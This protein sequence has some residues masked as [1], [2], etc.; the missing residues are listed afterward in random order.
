VSLVR[1]FARA[2]LAGQVIRRLRRAGVAEARYDAAT[3][4]VRFRPVGHDGAAIMSLEILLGELTGSRRERRARVDAFVDGFIRVPDMPGT[5]EQ[6]CPRLR[7]VLRGA[8]PMAGEKLPAPLRRPALP[9]LSELV[10]VDQPDT[11]TFVAP[12]LLDGWGVSEDE[13][14]AAART[15]LSQVVHRRAAPAPVVLRFVDDGDAYWTSHLLI[16]GWLAGLA[17]Q[18][19]GVPVAFAPERALLLVTAEGGEYLSG[20]FTLA[21]ELYVGSPRAIT[22]MAYVSDA[23]GRTVP[24]PAPAGHRLH[25]Q[26]TRAAGLLAV[27]EYAHQARSFA[28]GPTPLPLRLI[29]PVGDGDGWRTRAVWDR[30]EPALVPAADEVQCGSGTVPWAVIEPHLLLVAEVDPP[31]WHADGWPSSPDRSPTTSAAPDRD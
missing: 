1:R 18:V 24:Y 13:A 4:S 26:V 29:D 8:A 11:M 23:R 19:G 22:P 21:E 16:D 6:A 3:F 9:Y 12:D 28:A 2:R 27:H 25:R 30:D 5:W 20:L 10:V 7:P 17:E 31:R 14:F 15:N